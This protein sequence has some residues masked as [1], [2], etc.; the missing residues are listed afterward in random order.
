LSE[1][2]GA[3]PN[4]VSRF[5]L[6]CFSHNTLCICC[7]MSADLT[8]RWLEQLFAALAD[9]LRRRILSILAEHE[10]CVCY[11]VEV[12]HTVQP[13]VSRQLAYL[14][15][16]GLVETRRNGKWIHYRLRK[17]ENKAAAVVLAESLRQ[18]KH[19]RQ[20]QSDLARLAQCAHRRIGQLKD[21]P[22]PQATQR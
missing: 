14:R 7:L 6:S 2:S 4:S 21:A 13:V 9:P 17:P 11:L 22:S 1:Q 15:R 3:R 20:T 10:V 16:S 5:Y 8:S 18:L 19:V 12:L